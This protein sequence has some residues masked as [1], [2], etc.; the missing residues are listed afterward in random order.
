MKPTSKGNGQNYTI[1][2]QNPTSE[3]WYW[4]IAYSYTDANEVSPLTSSTSAS[5]GV[6]EIQVTR[7]GTDTDWL[8]A[9]S[10]I[11]ACAGTFTHPPGGC[12]FS[13]MT[14]G[15]DVSFDA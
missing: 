4:Q 11:S 3:H 9:L 6:L 8:L 5:N 15:N 12:D 14:T 7:A 1:A 2:L 10:T 13:A